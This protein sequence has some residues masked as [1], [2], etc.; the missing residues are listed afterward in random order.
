MYDYLTEEKLIE[1]SVKERWR[2]IYESAEALTK[3]LKEQNEGMMRSFVRIRMHQIKG[4]QENAP[5]SV[6]DFVKVEAQTRIVED[7]FRTL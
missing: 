2:Y 1:I 5:L 7:Y 3:S 6:P 4:I